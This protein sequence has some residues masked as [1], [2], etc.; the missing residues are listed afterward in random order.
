[1]NYEG[2]KAK[3]IGKCKGKHTCKWKANTQS[4]KMAHITHREEKTHWDRTHNT[5]KN[6]NIEHTK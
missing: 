3:Y 2:W 5:R 4:G 1:M 6:G